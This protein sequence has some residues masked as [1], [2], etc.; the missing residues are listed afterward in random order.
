MSMNW[1]T[2]DRAAM[3]AAAIVAWSIAGC[4]QT[5]SPQSHSAPQGGGQCCQQ[6]GAAGGNNACCAQAP[7]QS[8]NCCP[9]PV[10]LATIDESDKT[11]IADQKVCPVTEAQLGSMGDP[12]K[13]L[14]GK[15]PLYL[16]CQG[17][18]AKVKN[19]PESYLAK[20]GQLHESQ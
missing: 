19:A 15:Q 7:P 10:T 14:V 2:I 5:D 11:G 16:C 6:R 8:L 9:L 1:S 17:C 12:V 13:V 20:V 18:V 3:V 4:Q